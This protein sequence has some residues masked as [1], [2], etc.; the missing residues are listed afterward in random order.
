[1]AKPQ[2]DIAEYSAVEYPPCVNLLHNPVLGLITMFLDKLSER[3]FAF[4]KVIKPVEMLIDTGMSD[5][6]YVAFAW[7]MLAKI[8]TLLNQS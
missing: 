6:E 3:Q 8:S 2:D 4:L 1:M 7:I 5:T